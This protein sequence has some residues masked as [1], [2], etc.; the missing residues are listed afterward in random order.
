MRTVSLPINVKNLLKNRTVEINRIEYKEGWNPLKV[1]HTVCAFA[2]DYEE[3]GGGYIVIGVRDDDGFPGEVTG[4]TDG[5][6]AQIDDELIR[7]C[8]LLEPKYIPELSIETCEERRIAVIWAVSDNRRPFRCP[9]TLGTKRSESS[10]RAC[11][12]RRSSHTV[13]AGRDEENRLIEMSRRVSFDGSVNRDG[14]VGDIRRH[15]VDDYL[16]RVGSALAGRDLGNT[17][18]YDSMR[19]VGG[20]SEDRRPINV[21][22]MMFSDRPETFF[23]Y[24][25]TEVAIIL[26]EGRGIEEAVFD[27]PVD[28]QAIRALGYVRDRVIRERVV[29]VP[30][31]AEAQRFFNYPYEALEEIVVNALYHR[32]YEI[33]EPVKIYVYGDRIEVTSLPG[34]DPSIPD[35]DVS[36]LRLKGTFYRNKRLGDF[37]KELRLTEGRNT[38][39]D[40]IVGAMRRNGS[41]LPVYETDPD[42]TYLRVTVPVHPGFKGDGIPNMD[43]GRRTRRNAEELRA[44][45][46]DLL[47]GNGCLRSAQIAEMLGYS[48]VTPALRAAINELI[49]NGEAE[50]LYPERPNSSRQM[51]CRPG[52]VR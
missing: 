24:S 2:N 38:G 18:L 20:P 49:E 37:L 33:P 47:E 27:G 13:R 29:K 12:I 16:Q 22:L 28:V 4:L 21:A 32:S 5:E 15:I 9:V 39:M 3:S 52:R 34:P 26:P 46:L 41:P 17:E 44:A 36:S 31:K 8:N 45:V 50:Y 19:L 1:L 14:T 6:I 48:S 10:E 7:I 40:T 30:G 25:R 43:A 11:Y 35:A 51:I 23:P 42:R